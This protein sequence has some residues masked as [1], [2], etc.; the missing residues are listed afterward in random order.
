M[1]KEIKLLSEECNLIAV[2]DTTP[3]DLYVCEGFLECGDKRE[4]LGMIKLADFVKDFSRAFISKR[5]SF[6][7]L[8]GSTCAV[9]VEHLEDHIIFK[10]VDAD[11][12]P[13][14][15]S[16]LYE[17]DQEKWLKILKELDSL[18]KEEQQA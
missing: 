9:S 16:I 6:V 11:G 2:L 7:T 3:G 17:S 8:F 15:N 13:I 14:G 4:R 12:K 5:D 10:Y 1:V 18:L